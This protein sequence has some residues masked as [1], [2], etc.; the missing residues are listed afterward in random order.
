MVVLSIFGA[1]ADEELFAVQNRAF[2]ALHAAQTLA[3]A[4]IQVSCRIALDVEYLIGRQRPFCL[5]QGITFGNAVVAES[6]PA[7]A[8]FAL[9][10]EPDFV[11]EHFGKPV[12]DTVARRTIVD[13]S[14]AVDVVA[15]DSGEISFNP[16]SPLAIFLDRYYM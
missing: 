2:I 8:S 11:A 4:Y 9:V 15:R 3:G 7:A 13:K 16:Q 1:A 5:A 14:V 12:G 10:V 6:Y